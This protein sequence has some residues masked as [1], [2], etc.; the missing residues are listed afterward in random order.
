M[1]NESYTVTGQ[2]YKKNPMEVKSDKFSKIDF[3]IKTDGEYP[4]YLQI[5]ASNAKMSLLDNVNVGD[6]VTA[7]VNVKG[8]L[9]QSPQGEEKCF[10]TLE[11]WKCD[12]VGQSTQPSIIQHNPNRET[13]VT[14][15]EPSFDI[16]F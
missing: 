2:L 10:N 15:A 1:A 8:R 16:H 3:I 12:K 13:P 4:Q 6:T 9:W 5:Q 11:L 7:N 14:N